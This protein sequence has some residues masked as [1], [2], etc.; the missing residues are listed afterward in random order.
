MTLKVW[1]SANGKL[2]WNGEGHKDVITGI[3]FSPDGKIVLTGS[4]DGTARLWDTASG[5][6]IGQPKA[7]RDGVCAVAFSPDGKTVL[8][9]GFD[10][11][12][13][14]W[15]VATGQPMGHAL[16]SPRPV[17]SVAFS[18]DGR[19][20]LTGS[21]VKLSGDISDWT[22]QLWDAAT[23]QPIGAPMPHPP[24]R[25]ELLTV[26]FSPDDRVL[27]TSDFITV[28]LWDVPA[29][30]PADLVRLA[31]WIE[32]ATG[33]ELDEL[34]S[35]RTLERDA[36][37]ERRSRLER[38]GGPPPPDHAPRMDP[39]LFGPVPAARGDAWRERGQWD[40]AEAAYLEAIVA[41]PLN[42]PVRD[43]LVRQH[44]ERGHLDRAV[45]TVVEAVRLMPDDGGLREH[46]SL[47]LLLSGDRAGWQRSTAALLDRLGG[48]TNP[49][50]ANH[51]AW[52]CVLGPEATPDPAVPV[53]LAGIALEG[54]NSTDPN[55]LNTLGIAL[56]RASRYDE[57]IRRLE[58]AIRVRDGVGLPGD[59]AF[60]ALAHHRL[61]H[62]DAA[63]SWVDRL[64][65][66][67]P[68]MA[69]DQF[70]FELEVRLLRS[71]A[72]AVILYDPMFPGDPFAR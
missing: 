21:G 5:R 61:G 41:R 14:L 35:I 36:W 55:I 48:T 34:G 51:V 33:L 15:D 17:T 68:S 7:Y 44:I 69:P 39:I 10:E 54:V 8:T 4:R 12:A 57:A 64:R 2:L 18:P 70:W 45:A 31:A 46:L 23:G 28:R 20:I 42:V 6:P 58:Q 50:T 62:G 52:A 49:F 25:S 26:A 11:T 47:A 65:E 59:W 30:L 9:G 67:Q 32:A 43:A 71:E 1:D 19:T 56:Y 24:A 27:L 66:H 22:A 3:A 40:R 72:E 29:P 13:R 37:L 53:R 60:L 16:V 38:L 63:R